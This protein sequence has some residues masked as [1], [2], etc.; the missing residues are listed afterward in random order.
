MELTE[1]TYFVETDKI[2]HN[3]DVL[4]KRVGPAKIY[5]VVKCDGYGTG[6][7]AMTR[8][9]AENG[10]RRFAVTE[11]AEAQCVAQQTRPEELLM[12]TAVA[13]E[14]DM[15]TLVDCGATFTVAGTADAGR[16]SDFAESR[17]LRLNVHVKVDTGM[18]RR[19]FLPQQAEEILAVYRDYP[20]LHVTGIYTHFAHA[21]DPKA[22]KTQFEKFRAVLAALEQAGVDPGTRHCCNS[23]AAFHHPDMALDAVRVGSALLG[24]ILGGDRFGLRRTG[25][26]LAPVESVRQ[27]PGG[28]TI[29][30]GSIYRTRRQTTVA[31]CSVGGHHGFG[32]F[33]RP[34]CQSPMTGVLDLLAIIRNRLTG[35]D[36]PT[37]KIG[38]K[39]CRVLGCICTE[40]VMLD[41]TG[42][43]CHPGDI[44][45]F[46]INPMFLRD[47]PV[48][49]IP[50]LPQ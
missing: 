14:A 5:A 16:L 15:Q 49:Y 30:Y 29:G 4:R 8:V 19:G 37:A 35:R 21:F 28:S 25:I 7:A 50:G 42:I 2:A 39:T 24:R 36:I 6:C 31:L 38:G 33:L 40:A 48:R 20:A 22:T 46:D 26:C 18:G 32:L 41:V 9:C 47:I 1:K 44:A 12:L 13:G 10:L 11:V 17:G 34:G 43:P 3:I 45:A 27:L 23:V